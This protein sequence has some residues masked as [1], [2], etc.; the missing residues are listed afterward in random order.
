MTGLARNE[1]E[2]IG[3]VRIGMILPCDRRTDVRIDLPEGA[4]GTHHP[5]SGTGYVLSGTPVVGRRIVARLEGGTVGIWID[6][7]FAGQST[8][9]S[10]GPIVE[11]ESQGARLHDCPAGRGFHWSTRIPVRLP[12]RIELLARDNVLLVV[13]ALDVETYLKGVI[14]SEMGA[15]SPMAFLKAQCVVARSWMTANAERKH[16]DLSVDFCNDD[17]CQRYQGIGSVDAR[18]SAAVDETAGL[19]LVHRSGQVVDANYSKCCGGIVEDPAAVWGVDKP[20]QHSLVD[21][22]QGDAIFGYDPVG[23]AN[24]GEFVTGDWLATTRAFCG[25]L[26]VRPTDMSQYLGDVDDGCGR[27][28]WSISYTAD[29]LATLLKRPECATALSADVS[30]LRW[31]DQLCVI[32]R[33]RSGRATE[34]AVDYRDAQDQ[35]RRVTIS[36]QYQIRRALHKSFLFSSAFDVRVDRDGRGRPTRFA[37]DGAG[38]GHGCGMCQIGALGMALGG[39]SYQ[40]ICGHYFTDV[41]IRKV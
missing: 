33:G 39:K 12:G 19:V 20:G 18:V 36:D 26:A 29:E 14:S 30:S 17:C 28:R 8:S 9:W 31:V 21:A 41:T 23:C 13:N 37:L 3:R 34:L 4:S 7:R 25:P 10:L 11:S 35:R 27:F 2:R 22:P 5:Q 24:I 1:R 16:V 15:A 40:E 32:R 6:G 38:W